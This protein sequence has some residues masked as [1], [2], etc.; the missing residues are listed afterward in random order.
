MHGGWWR[1]SDNTAPPGQGNKAF[2]GLVKAGTDLGR[3]TICIY[4]G[5][6]CLKL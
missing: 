3:F 4:R 5:L 6:S 1:G 2:E